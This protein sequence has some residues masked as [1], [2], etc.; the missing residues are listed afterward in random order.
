MRAHSVH[1]CT[2]IRRR[3]KIKYLLLKNFVVV[4]NSWLEGGT[5]YFRVLA[6]SRGTGWLHFSKQLFRLSWM[7]YNDT[8]YAAEPYDYAE[9]VLGVHGNI[10]ASNAIITADIS[11]TKWLLIV[12][13]VLSY[14]LTHSILKYGIACLLLVTWKSQTRYNSYLTTTL[15]QYIY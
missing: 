1:N 15:P 7:A 12:E 6:T 8:L 11:V 10:L 3:E 4:I 13:L 9:H 14:L 5:H 2:Q